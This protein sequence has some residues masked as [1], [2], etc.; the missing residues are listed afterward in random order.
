[1][2]RDDMNRTVGRNVDAQECGRCV[3][4]GDRVWS[5]REQRCCYPTAEPEDVVSDRVDPPMDTPERAP[6]QPML[7]RSS[8]ETQGEQLTAADNA[9]L[10]RC[11]PSDRFVMADSSGTQVQSSTQEESECT[12]V[13][14]ILDAL[15]TRRTRGATS[16]PN[17]MHP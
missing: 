16:A 8:A 1:M 17:V 4:A 2:P 6:R 9:E 15:R 7:N 5:R 11:E 14:H 3:V 13:S 10:L 12:R